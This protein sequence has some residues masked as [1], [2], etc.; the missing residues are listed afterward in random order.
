[1]NEAQETNLNDQRRAMAALFKEREAIGLPFRDWEDRS[2]ISSNSAYAW[3]YG[4]RAPMLCNIVALAE[5]LGFE[6]IM[7]KKEKQ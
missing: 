6:L 2:G 3:R 1:M 4:K 7:R 5:T